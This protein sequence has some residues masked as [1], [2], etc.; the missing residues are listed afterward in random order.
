MLAKNLAI[1]FLP[2]SDNSDSSNTAKARVTAKMLN[3]T[4]LDESDLYYGD[5]PFASTNYEYKVE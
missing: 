1:T 2:V 4:N 5:F 3:Y